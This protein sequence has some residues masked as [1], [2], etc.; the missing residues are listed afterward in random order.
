MK[1]NNKIKHINIRIDSS[2]SKKI[3]SIQSEMERN[4]KVKLNRS[5][6]LEMLIEKGIEKYIDDGMYPFGD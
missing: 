4:V 6:V 1:T 5:Q 2:L 3:E